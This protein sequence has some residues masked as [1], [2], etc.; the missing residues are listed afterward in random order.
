MSDYY[1]E[2]IDVLGI[3]DYIYE[4]NAENYLFCVTLKKQYSWKNYILFLRTRKYCYQT[5]ATV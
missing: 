2:L 4:M 5:N 1:F 3:L